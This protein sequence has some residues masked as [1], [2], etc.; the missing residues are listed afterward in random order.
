MKKI[1]MILILLLIFAISG[2][3]NQNDVNENNTPEKEV[4]EITKENYTD[5]NIIINYPQISNLNDNEKQIRIN[6]MIK[7]QALEVLENYK[8]GI[9]DLNLEMDY[10]IK[11]QGE[12]ILS[13]QYIGLSA[14]KGAAYPI[15]EFN[16]ANI[17][18]ENEQL[19][20]LIDV[21]TIND[22][23]IEKFNAG[24]YVAYSN[25]LNLESEGALIDALHNFDNNSL[26]ESLN[27]K[28]TK[29]YFTK[30]SLVVSIELPHVLGD[31]L[32]ME[33]KYDD[34]GDLLLKTPVN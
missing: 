11:Y 1:I 32:E 30:D 6:E 7:S 27:K 26:I 18:L 17:D 16:T 23:F 9:S 33:I 19:L 21:V 22:K 29:F 8:D 3:E 10:E 4:Y 2:C 5:N 14:M 25:S 34:L 13:I 31:H 28:T 12:D 24:K 15:N 20:K